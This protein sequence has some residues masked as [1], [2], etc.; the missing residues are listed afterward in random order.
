M[1]NNN[2]DIHS[3][4]EWWSC[5]WW[6]FGWKLYDK[7]TEEQKKKIQLEHDDDLDIIIWM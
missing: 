7:Q 3:S 6:C 2:K 5:W 4:T 1:K